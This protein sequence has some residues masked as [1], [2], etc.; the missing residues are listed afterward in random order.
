MYR[1]IG[2]RT[3]YNGLFRYTYMR[4]YGGVHI[5]MIQKKERSESTATVE[6]LKWV[7]ENWLAI[8]RLPARDHAMLGNVYYQTRK[9]CIEDIRWAIYC[10][11]ICEIKHNL[12]ALFVCCCGGVTIT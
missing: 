5:T 3:T 1:G 12:Y 7:T 6:M 9:I 2:N 10:C 11:R 8:D 4:L